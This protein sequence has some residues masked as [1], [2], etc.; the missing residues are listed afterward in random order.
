MQITSKRLTD[1]KGGF[2]GGGVAYRHVVVTFI[3]RP[4]YDVDR[5]RVMNPEDHAYIAPGI[6]RVV[7]RLSRRVNIFFYG[8]I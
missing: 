8:R 4:A 6:I 1:R 7:V 5:D 3:N 2:A